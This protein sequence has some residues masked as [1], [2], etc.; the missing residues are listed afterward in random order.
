MRIAPYDLCLICKNFFF[1]LPCRDASR[2]LRQSAQACECRRRVFGQGRNHAAN[3]ARRVWPAGLAGYDEVIG[4][5][6]VSVT[7]QRG[8]DVRA[9]SVNHLNPRPAIMNLATDQEFET[10][11]G[12]QPCPV[13]A[14]P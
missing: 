8:L 11:I 10:E 2:S 12:G 6:V 4:G 1:P 5:G 14:S 7:T 9:M 13:P 3:I